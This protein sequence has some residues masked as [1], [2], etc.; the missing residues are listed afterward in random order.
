MSNNNGGYYA[1]KGFLYQFDKS[2]IE[3]LR[4]PD[5]KVGIEKI[6]DI[7]INNYAIQVKHKETQN[8]SPSKIK[9]AV[10]QLIDLFKNDK[11]QKFCLY[12]YFKNKSPCL[13]KLNLTE[14]DKIIGNK[15][16][17]YLP[18]LKKEFLNNFKINFSNN[19]EEQFEELINIIKKSF[20][21]T[22][23]DK[24]I[25]Y[26]SIFRSKLFDISIKTKDER[27]ISKNDLLL[28]IEDAEKTIFYLSYSK[29]LS[30]EK[31]E[32]IIRKD[33]FTFIAANIDNFER[34][35]KGRILIKVNL[36]LL[37]SFNY[38]DRIIIGGT[39]RFY[40]LIK[41]IYTFI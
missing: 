33:F 31:Y 8:Y 9:D 40:F 38:Y 41:R 20:S 34:L 3:I 10:I 24:A 1:I 25:I 13:Y 36:N 2:L 4:N 39:S 26:H 21:L 27:E 37:S 18:Y 23:K 15:K 22:S 32:K 11:S 14:L 30:K 29:Y 28:F 19:Y 5:I 7:D 6:Q 35:F 17:K 12:C 16:D